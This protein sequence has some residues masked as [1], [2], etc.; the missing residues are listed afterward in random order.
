[1]SDESDHVPTNDEEWRERLSDEEYRILREAGTETPFSGEYVDHKADGSYACAGC[2]AELFDSETKFD[3][4]CGWPSFYDADDDRIETRTDT[5]HGM[6]R[7][8]VVCANCGGH[9]GHVF[10]DG[11]E[12]TGKRYCINSVALEFDE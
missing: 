3:S 11:P 4:G 9:L 8:E 1:M 7:T 2:G 6:R 5:S 10:D 12:P